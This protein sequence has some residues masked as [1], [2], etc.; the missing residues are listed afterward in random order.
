MAS[1]LLARLRTL[2]AVWRLE[3][4]AEA[5]PPP[6]TEEAVDAILARLRGRVG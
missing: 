2:V 1:G 3:D 5:E 4:R 6:L